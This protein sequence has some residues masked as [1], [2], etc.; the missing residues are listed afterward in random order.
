MKKIL[1]TGSNGFF[2]Y[3]CVQYFHK[4][5]D[6]ICAVGRSR[7][8]GQKIDLEENLHQLGRQQFN[9]VLHFAGGS[10]VAAS[11]R[12]PEEERAKTISSLNF[13]L[14]FMLGQAPEATLIYPSSAAVYGNNHDGKIKETDKLDPISPYGF[15]KVE[16]EDLC[17]EYHRKYGLNIQ[18]IRF[19]SVYGEYLR[20]QV[21]FDICKN[22]LNNEKF[23]C[24]G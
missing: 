7:K 24:F 1:V 12:N 3:N 20:K 10:S 6:E 15:H 4:Q 19:F 17:F 2:G 16:A 11:I 5:G 23:V 14:Q 21:V 18:I 8:D 9:V 13:V 22:I